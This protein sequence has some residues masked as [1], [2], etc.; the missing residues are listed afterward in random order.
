MRTPIFLVLFLTFVTIAQSYNDL[1][2]KM[3]CTAILVAPGASIDGSA[4]TTHNADCLDCDWRLAR[5]PSKSYPPGSTKEILKYTVS[6]SLL[7]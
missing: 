1:N 6:G 2:E 5:S 4:M 3:G 7:S